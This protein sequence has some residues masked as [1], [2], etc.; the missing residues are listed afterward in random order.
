MLFAGG[1]AWAQLALGGTGAVFSDTGQSV[2]SIVDMFKDGEGIFYGPLI[3]LGMRNIAIGAA[4]NWSYYYTDFGNTNTKMVDYDLNGYLQGHLISY[5]SP[6][7]PFLEV[8]FGEIA[9]DYAED[10]PDSSAPLRATKYFQAG[11]GLGVNLG[12]LG[13]FV[14]AL[15]MIPADDP[16]IVESDNGDSY[17]LEE[18]PLKPLKV[19]LGAKIIL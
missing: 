18:Y 2:E 11:G 7:D 9:T 16:V 19:F 6:I 13:I 15:Y 4:F 3:E 8:G 5:K 1:S 10:D 14:K 17:S 12:N